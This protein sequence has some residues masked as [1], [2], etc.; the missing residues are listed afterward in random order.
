MWL[1]KFDNQTNVSMLVLRAILWLYPCILVYR[2]L[3]LLSR[4]ALDNLPHRIQPRHIPIRHDTDPLRPHVLEVHAHFFRAT[5]SKSDTRC[6]H[7]EGILSLV[8]GI[9]R[10][11]ER[12][13]GMVQQRGCLMLTWWCMTRAAW[14]MCILYG[15]QK[16]GRFGSCIFRNTNGKGHCD[17]KMTWKYRTASIKSRMRQTMLTI[18]P[19]QGAPTLRV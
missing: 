8:G 13:L 9:N 1:S 12:A 3:D 5:W 7:L 14:G 10:R 18:K 11:G 2:E 15:P 4:Q 16:I 17:L 6:R 19:V